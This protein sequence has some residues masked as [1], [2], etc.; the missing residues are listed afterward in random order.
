METSVMFI[1]QFLKLPNF[2]SFY[3]EVILPSKIKKSTAASIENTDNKYFEKVAAEYNRV[4]N[5]VNYKFLKSRKE[6]ADQS[7][8][9]RLKRFESL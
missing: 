8:D 6:A 2:T 1:Y 7:A 9:A 3:A 5:I 4:L